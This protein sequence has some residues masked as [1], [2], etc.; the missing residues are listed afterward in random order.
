PNM[1]ARIDSSNPASRRFT[2]SISCL[3]LYPPR[4][5]GVHVYKITHLGT[6][7]QRFDLHSGN[8]VRMQ[9]RAEIG[10]DGWIHKKFGDEFDLDGTAERWVGDIEAHIGI[11]L[12]TNLGVKPGSFVCR[13]DSSG[14]HLMPTFD[15]HE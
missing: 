9:N 2:R 15:R 7:E 3:R 14:R 12:L 6:G 4:N 1:S 5:R 10:K 11:S 8:V 13:D